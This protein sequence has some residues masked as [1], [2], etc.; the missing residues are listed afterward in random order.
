MKH[1]SKRTLTLLLTLLLFTSVWQANIFTAQAFSV[2]R[3]KPSAK[4]PH[5][6]SAANPFYAGGYQSECTWYVWGR[7]YEALGEKPNLPN[8]AA[9]CWYRWNASQNACP[10]G[11]T[12][13]VGAVMVTVKDGSHG[14]VAFV[15]ELYSNGTMLI[16]EYNY[17]VRNGFSTQVIRQ[18]P[19]GARRGRAH[20]VLGYIYVTDAKAADTTAPKISALKVAKKDAEGFVLSA[21]ASDKT[22]V[23]AVKFQVC[24]ADREWESA[25]WFD[26]AYSSESGR[27][28][29]RIPVSDFGKYV[30]P[31]K[32]RCHAYDAAGNRAADDM[33]VTMPEERTNPVPPISGVSDQSLPGA[34]SSAAEADQNGIASIRFP[35]RVA[36]RSSDDALW[37]DAAFS[38][39][40]DSQESRLPAS[41]AERSSDPADDR[42]VSET[43][44]WIPCF[45]CCTDAVAANGSF[46]LVQDLRGW[47][48]NINDVFK[49]SIA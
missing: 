25:V 35:A 47:A 1:R 42:P 34:V 18:L 24:P 38:A 32:V 19:A 30:G 14:H 44:A 28:T 20:K 33:T 26:A 7:A 37:P 23:T 41:G 21:K 11:A 43:A 40:N 16:S 29:C 17:N 9:H 49:A 8:A 12:P 46:D 4:D 27:W 36:E 22:G 2:R 39:K 45:D 15:E 3:T 48:F 13:K 5:Y 6:Y 31:Y 10:Y